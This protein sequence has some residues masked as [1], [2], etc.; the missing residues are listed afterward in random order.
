MQNTINR[1]NATLA[2]LRALPR[3]RYDAGRSQRDSVPL[4][5]HA[6]M[7]ADADRV[8]PLE[9]LAQQDKSR[10]EEL[11]PLRYGR[12][13]RTP[14]TFLRGAA[15]VMASDLAAGFTDRPVGRTL[16]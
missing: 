10:L 8:D 6:E 11:I 16:R 5:S 4:E 1:I 15:A 13:S 2:Y 7:V 14:F 9:I 3:D 12:M